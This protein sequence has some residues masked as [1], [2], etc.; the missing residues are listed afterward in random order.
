ML[1]LHG[2]G[3]QDAKKKVSFKTLVDLRPLMSKLDHNKISNC[4]VTLSSII[5]KQSPNTIYI[6]ALPTVFRLVTYE[7]TKR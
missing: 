2:A 6:N 1:I 4:P 5:K 7:M 3:Y